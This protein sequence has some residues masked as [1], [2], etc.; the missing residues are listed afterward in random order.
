MVSLTPA[1]AAYLKSMRDGGSG[2]RP[3]GLVAKGL[4]AYRW[5]CS[6]SFGYT[7]TNAGRKALEQYEHNTPPSQ[8]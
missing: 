8:P 3:H 5:G 7:M 6:P 1:Q 2:G 4:L